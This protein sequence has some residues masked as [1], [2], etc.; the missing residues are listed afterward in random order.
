MY[1]EATYGNVHDNTIYPH[2]TK[3]VLNHYTVYGEVHFE[4]GSGYYSAQNNY[5]GGPNNTTG[6]GSEAVIYFDGPGPTQTIEVLNNTIIMSNPVR[7]SYAIEI[8][9][10]T[11]NSSPTNTPF[12]FAYNTINQQS[13]R[14]IMVD[15]YPNYGCSGG[16]NLDKV[17][18]VKEAGNERPHTSDAV[19]NKG[20]F[21]GFQIPGFHQQ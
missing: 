7:D 1:Y 19:S 14:G 11:T 2:H 10:N 20:R 6:Y 3:S 16:T 8:G 13:G 18:S 17:G 15:T 4:H 12:E 9:C 5:I 21:R